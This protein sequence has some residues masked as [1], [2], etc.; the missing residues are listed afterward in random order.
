MY[1]LWNMGSFQ[2]N[3]SFQGI[4]LSFSRNIL[5]ESWDFSDPIHL[6][7]RSMIHEDSWLE[8]L[9]PIRKEIKPFKCKFRKF[10]TAK[11]VKL[12]CIFYILDVWPVDPLQ[13]KLL[14]FWGGKKNCQPI[15]QVA[16][17]WKSFSRDPLMVSACPKKKERENTFLYMIASCHTPFY[18]AWED[19]GRWVSLSFLVGNVLYVRLGLSAFLKKMILPTGKNQFEKG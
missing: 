10:L 8:T 4:E 3:V 7:F 6:F 17:P 18:S 2:C 11:R 14:W 5:I 16:A 19:D 9:T 13:T 15:C 12:Q 1:F